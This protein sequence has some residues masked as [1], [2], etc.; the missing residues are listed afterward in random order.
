M[1]E[2]CPL[3]V[4]RSALVSESRSRFRVVGGL[5]PITSPSLLGA[6]G[7]REVGIGALGGV[8]RR[9]RL[10]LNVCLM[11]AALY[12]ESSRGGDGDVLE[13]TVLW[14]FDGVS[15]SVGPYVLG[16]SNPSGIRCEAGKG[17]IIAGTGVKSRSLRRRAYGPG[18]SGEDLDFSCL[19]RSVC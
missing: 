15:G 14:A 18:T 12:R 8:G 10:L 2:I 1:G 19:S 13:R 9:I 6:R 5:A 3:F 11:V 16:G 7:L 17:F 4:G